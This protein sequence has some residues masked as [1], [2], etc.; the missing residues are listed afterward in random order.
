MT[1]NNR[2]LTIG[3]KGTDVWALQ[4]FLTVDGSGPQSAKLAAV[5]TTGY[6]GP[7]TARALTEFQA[8]VGITPAL[9]YFGPKTRAYVYGIY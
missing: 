3:S 7:L 2:S 5:G 8:E 9:G 1:N 4:V 6:F